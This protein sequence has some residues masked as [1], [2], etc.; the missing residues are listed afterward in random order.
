MSAEAPKSTKK[1]DELSKIEQEVQKRWD[2]EHVFEVNAPKEGEQ[3]P[4]KY[5]VTFPY[6][7]MNGRLHLGH[8]FTLMKCEFAVGF[9]R[10]KGKRCLFPFGLHCTGMPI[11][12]C[13]DKLKREI[14][15]FGNPPKFPEDEEAKTAAKQHSKV[16]AKTGGAKYQWDIM[17]A[18]DIA[19]EDIPKFQE[20]EYWLH[21]FPPY[22]IKDLK[23]LGVKVDWRRS[24]I[25]TDVNPY[26]DSFVRWQFN[27]L[28]RL[29]KI[30]FGKRET[31]FSPRDNQPCA[32]HDRQTGEGVGSQEYTLIKIEVLAPFPAALQTLSGRRVFL[33]AATLRPETMYG[34]TNCW[35]HPDIT[36]CAFETAGGDVFVCTRRAARGMSYQMVTPEYGVVKELL[37]VPG[38]ALMGAR[39]H[40]PLTQYKE[41]YALPMMSIKENKGTGVVT[42]VPSDAPD[43]HAAL[44]DLQ[45]K[46]ALREKYGISDAMVSFAPVEIIETPDYGRLAAVKA[47]DEFKVKSQNDREQLDKAKEVVYQKGFYQG[48]MLVGPYAGQPVATAKPLMQKMMLESGEALKYFEPESTVMSRSGEECVVALCDQW[49]IVYGEE[50]WK[51]KAFEC[52]GNMECFDKGT[53]NSFE[54]ALKGL[55]EY[56]CSRTYG[57]GTRLPWDP[58]WLIESLSD[59]TIYMSYYTVAHLLQGGTLDGKGTSPLGITPQQM[60]DAAWDFVFLGK[61]YSGSIAQDKIQ[62]LRREFLY[63]YPLDLRV[64]GRDLVPN[65]LSFFIYNHVAIFPREMWPRAVRANGHLLLNGE[66]MSKST[67]NFLTLSD[68]CARYTADVARLGLADAGDSLDD[69][70]FEEKAANATILRVHSLLEWI[71]E[72]L[73]DLPAL[74]AGPMA[75]FEDRLFLTEINTCIAQAHD[76]YEKMHYR[77]ALKAAFFEMQAAKQRYQLVASAGPGMHRDL[78]VHF[79]A[80][81]SLLMAPIT[82]HVCEHV[83]S[84]L[85]HKDSIMHARWPEAGSVDEALLRAGKHLEEVVHDL[86]LRLKTRMQPPKKKGG[87]EPEKP[88]AVTTLTIYVSKH[89]PGWQSVMLKY[90]GGKYAS[91][92]GALPENQ[93][94]VKEAQSMEELKPHMKKVM[95]FVAFVKAEVAAKGAQALETTV[96]FDELQLFKDQSPFLAKTLGLQT[97]KV[98]RAEDCADAKIRDNCTPGRPFSSFE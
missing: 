34:Q 87:S 53:L 18:M 31:V 70:N 71:E 63:F 46:A 67:G 94:I 45:N 65:H 91:G 64:S 55:H 10:M 89:Y 90:L 48:V 52:L 15:Q 29:D 14:A 75:A 80:M 39:L 97:V 78:V 32:D 26:Y 12:A 7:Y 11:K 84:L 86:R 88:V 2:A 59:S 85:G 41:I 40:A 54:S 28:K 17:R 76:A 57:L 5:F 58:D 9:Q 22:A 51:S 16:A 62:Q 4:E 35:L 74:R 50:E 30:R 43:D 82:P 66:K 77:A 98:E 13:A 95:P 24:F 83:W 92:G 21:Y 8:T 44:R 36:Y 96:P 56:A 37:Q 60:D 20:A 61:P 1:K 47:C 38:A 81:Q 72:V 19:E 68:A 42:S 49:Y 25:T 93:D 6:P 33:V 79:I 3:A 23:A 73:R 27:T 69:A